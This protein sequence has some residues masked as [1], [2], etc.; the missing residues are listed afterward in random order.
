MVRNVKRAATMLTIQLR[1]WL[2]HC[3]GSLGANH[4]GD[5]GAQALSEALPSCRAL[6]KL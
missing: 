1:T 6:A 4:I 3:I 5:A 2:Q